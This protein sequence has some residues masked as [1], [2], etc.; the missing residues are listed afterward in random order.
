[1]R[2]EPKLPTRPEK[3]IDPKG[4]LSK[5]V[6]KNSKT[7]YLNTVHNR[8]ISEHLRLIKVETKC[9]SFAVYPSFLGKIFPKGSHINP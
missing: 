4:W 1:M 2:N 5:L 8:R 7:E 3:V 6:E 9:P